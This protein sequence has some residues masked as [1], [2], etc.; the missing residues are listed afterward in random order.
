VL[1][2]AGLF[3]LLLWRAVEPPDAS[4]DEVLVM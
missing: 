1:F 3:A 4:D 2:T